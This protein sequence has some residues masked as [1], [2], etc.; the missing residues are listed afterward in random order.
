MATAS[1][2]RGGR[3]PLASG[4][5]REEVVGVI[6]DAAKAVAADLGALGVAVPGPFD[7]ERGVSAI[8]HKL[9]ALYGVDLRREL[10]A[11]LGVGPDAVVFLNDTAAFLL[12]EGWAGAARGHAR[13]VG[14][15]LGT[16]LGSAFLADGRIV[17]SGSDVPPGGELYTLAF[18]G[19]PVEHAISRAALLARYGSEASAGPDVEE[20][21]A[22]ARGGD[23]RAR[24][25]FEELATNLAAFLDPVLRRFRPSCLVIGGSIA[26][27]WDLLGEGLR[28]SLDSG[29]MVARAEHLEDAPLLG[30]AL[31]AAARR[32]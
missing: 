2:E 8:T 16:G 5:G 3:T 25:V 11:A 17:R 29:L 32:P 13:A 4:A 18:R 22:L 24:H 30:A 7:Y 23:A 14:I 6:V 27:A 28:S 31:A 10:T 1:V 12:G 15:T 20:I 26:G 9:G 21:A 19:A